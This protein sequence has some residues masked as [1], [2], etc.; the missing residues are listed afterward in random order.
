MD[1]SQLSASFKIIPINYS[2]MEQGNIDPKEKA[3][4][5]FAN[6]VMQQANAALMF[7]GKV[8]N[9]ETGEQMKDLGAAQYFIDQIEMLETKTRG[10]LGVEEEKLLKETLMTVRLA[11]VEATRESTGTPTANL[12]QPTP[13][14]AQT[15]ESS[16]PPPPRETAKTE[17]TESTEDKKKFVK[18]Y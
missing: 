11:F 13:Q 1:W 8:K 2:S 15:A 5:L 16:A 14:A 10:N 6:L 18:K 12:E 7:M 3:A 4:A 9:P 17:T